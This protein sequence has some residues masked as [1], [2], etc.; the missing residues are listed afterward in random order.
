MNLR[1]CELEARDDIPD[2]FRNRALAIRPQ[3]GGEQIGCTVYEI[4]TGRQLFPYHWHINNDEWAVVVAGTPIL[5]TPD[6]ETELRA[7]DVVGFPEGEAG[8]HTFSNRGGEP[9]RVAIFSTLRHGTSMYPDADKI[10][11][12]PRD[13]RRWYR[14]ADNVDYWDGEAGR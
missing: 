10:G 11:A 12:G 13:D 8:A 4:P 7:G 14:R 5:R 1:D 2:A 9:A 3:I 6:G